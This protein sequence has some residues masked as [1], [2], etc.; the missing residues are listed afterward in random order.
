MRRGV[1]S[2][3]NPTSIPV[4]IVQQKEYVELRVNPSSFQ[5]LPIK[6]R[7]NFIGYLNEIADIIESEGSRAMISGVKI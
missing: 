4:D 1:R 7:M 3:K 2:L 6:S 5:K